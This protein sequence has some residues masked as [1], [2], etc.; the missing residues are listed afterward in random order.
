MLNFEGLVLV[1]VSQLL[2]SFHENSLLHY[3]LSDF[4]FLKGNSFNL[5][6]KIIAAVS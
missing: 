2:M 4:L 1:T 5:H 6:L 3:N